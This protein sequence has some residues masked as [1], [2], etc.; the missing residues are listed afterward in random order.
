MTRPA[1]IDAADDHGSK[2][3]SLP[4]RWAGFADLDREFLCRMLLSCFTHTL[5]IYAPCNRVKV[6]FSFSFHLDKLSSVLYSCSCT[7]R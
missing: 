7:A 2:S 6:G 5:I 4:T 1:G 3:I